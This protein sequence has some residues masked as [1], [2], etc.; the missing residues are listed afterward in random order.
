M[1]EALRFVNCTDPSAIHDAFLNP[2]RMYYRFVLCSFR[3]IEFKFMIPQLPDFQ[4][5][6]IEVNVEI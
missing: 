1:P 6:V 4:L 2:F 3:P 5:N